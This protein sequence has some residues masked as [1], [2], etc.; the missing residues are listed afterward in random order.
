MTAALDL[1]PA[2]A[3]RA[4][5]AAV[6]DRRARPGPDLPARHRRRAGPRRRARAAVDRPADP[7][8]HRP[9]HVAARGGRA[10]PGQPPAGGAPAAGPAAAAASGVRE[11]LGNRPF[12]RVL[13][14]ARCSSCRSRCS[15]SWSRWRRCCWR[16]RWPASAS[17]GSRATTAGWSARGSSGR[18][19]G[20]ALCALA[21]PATIVSI[22][23]LEGVGARAARARAPAAAHARRRGRPGARDAGRAAR[24]PLAEHRLLAAG[25]RDLRRRRR[26]PG[27]AARTPAPAARGRRST[28]RACAWRRSSTTPSSTPRPSS[29]PR[30]RSAAALA[31]DNERLKAELRA[32][33]EE[34]RVS[35]LRIVE[36]ADDARRR[37]ERDL[38]DGA[39]QQLVALALDLRML[40]ARLGDSGLAAHGRRDRREARGRAGRAAR[41]RARHP[42]RVPVRAR[43][44]RG[45]R[46]AGGAGAAERRGEVELDRAPARAGRGRRVLRGR[47]GADQ[48]RPL[49][50]DAQRDACSV[51]RRGGEVVVVVTDDG[52]GGATIEGGTGLRGLIDRL[53]VLDG[54]LEVPA[55]PAG[56]APGG[57]HPDRGAARWW[58][59]RRRSR[60]PCTRARRAA[61]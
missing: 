8:R 20:I 58:P 14:D 50:R 32:R 39:Q 9:A 55:R 27:R 25:A 54:R 1:S 40:K 6:P 28:T 41:V 34:L 57:A 60:W 26:P 22:A 36:A 49:R 5:G 44:R 31:I 13:R 53:A 45:G 12:W 46:G 35:R 4:A 16:S 19:V 47:R 17:A 52:K 56:H 3:R 24:R 48:R 15:G 61:P 10:A 51:S 18:A 59:R 29:S 43:R 38:H 11:Q 7:R 2:P 42:S 33:V 23:A 21:L 37:I 30:P